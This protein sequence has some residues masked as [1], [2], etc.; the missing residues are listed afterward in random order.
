VKTTN[1]NEKCKAS[2]IGVEL[3]DALVYGYN[4]E[5]LDFD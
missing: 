5:S 1:K 4:K 2:L 3:K